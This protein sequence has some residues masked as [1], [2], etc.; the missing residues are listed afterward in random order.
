MS[1]KA[2]ILFMPDVL[3]WEKKAVESTASLLFGDDGYEILSLA[4]RR[5]KQHFDIFWMS[6]R[7][8]RLAMRYLKAC[9]SDTTWISLFGE[10][11]GLPSLLGSFWKQSFP[12]LTSQIKLL[13]HSPFGYRRLCELENVKP[14][15]VLELPLAFGP[16]PTNKKIDSTTGISVFSA[17]NSEADLPYWVNI[18]HYVNQ[19]R[20]EAKFHFCGRGHLENHLNELVQELGLSDKVVLYP[21]EK[22]LEALSQSQ[23]MFFGL[24]KNYHFLSL[25][26]AA[27]TH[28]AAI[29]SELMGVDKWILDG[30][31]GFI[32]P[33]HDV[34]AAGELILRFLVDNDFL[35][36]IAANLKVRLE[37]ENSDLR[38]ASKWSVLHPSLAKF[39]E[40]APLHAG[41][42]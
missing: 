41:M 5:T 33:A 21:H 20:P 10:S 15:N 38:I 39:N 16:I 28:Q 34:K 6:T 40:T 26:M 1:K 7:N 3:S 27:K 42:R 22:Y 18:C 8:W 2:A 11:R 35:H 14:E 25:Q 9:H 19:F 13:A 4:D 36:K 17:W 12:S 23:V 24:M 37:T 31:T 30:K 32:V 29:T